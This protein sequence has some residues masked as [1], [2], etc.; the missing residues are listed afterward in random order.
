MQ[1]ENLDETDLFRTF[2]LRAAFQQPLVRWELSSYC[3]VKVTM[4]LCVIAPEIALTVTCVVA[5]AAGVVAAAWGA[6]DDEQPV[7]AAV[8]T[9]S[10]RAK[11]DPPA[12]IDLRFRPANASSPTGPMNARV[13]PVRDWNKGRGRFAP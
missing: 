8:A 2:A 7:I 4:T 5:G 6:A 1:R 9:T 13:R 10:R 11:R 12:R 3:T